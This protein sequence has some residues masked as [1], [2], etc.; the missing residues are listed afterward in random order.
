M[1][2]LHFAAVL[3]LLALA[4]SC[5]KSFFEPE[6]SNTP[7]AIFENLWQTFQR[8]YG[9][10]AERKIDWQS[11]YQQYRPMVDAHTSDDSLFSVLSGMLGTLNDGHVNLFAPG[12]VA[13][14][15]NRIRNA[16]TDAELFDLPLIKQGYL[17]DKFETDSEGG[18]VLGLLEHDIVYVHLPF[19]SGNMVALGRA[20]DEFPQAKGIIV[21]LRHNDGGDFTWAFSAIGHFV[22]ER[23]M[24]F[25][26]RTKN[27]A[28]PEDF[29]DW[30][31]W[32]VEPKAPY[33]N[34][35]MVLL[36]DRYTISAGERAAMA[37]QT[38]ENCITL[39]D[40]TCGAQSTMVAGE[41]ANGWKYTIATQ[42][43][44]LAN[45]KSYEGVGLAPDIYLKNDL[46]AL[47]N[48]RDQVLDAA[49]NRLK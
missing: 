24:V 4:V 12:R 49:I 48:G 15:S 30:Y 27:G 3:T 35:P 33:S 29:T 1:K 39:G 34:K 20:L 5:K 44:L 31:E 26:S 9:P 18:F 2:T 28:G 46:E 32:Y 38:L 42:Q 36:T 19:V 6:P 17:H 16:Q 22:P 11:V 41:L 8:D 25:R 40:T 47:K 21:D 23:R 7:E 13:F 10:F 43:T 45:G 14:N 37:F